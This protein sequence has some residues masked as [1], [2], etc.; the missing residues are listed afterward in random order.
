MVAG[1]LFPCLVTRL[2]DFLAVPLC[3]I[4]NS[5]KNTAI[6]PIIWKKEHVTVIPKCR[7]PQSL[8]D[9]RNISCTLL[10]SKIMESYVLQWISEE[11]TI[12][13]RQYGGVK[14]CGAPHLLIDV[15]DKICSGLED[16]RAACLLTSVDYAKAFNRLDYRLSLIHI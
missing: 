16:C 1:D 12:S 3:S 13:D 2:A 8:N 4:F 5:I 14:G 10:I 9:L 11:I 7:I 15:W 6:W